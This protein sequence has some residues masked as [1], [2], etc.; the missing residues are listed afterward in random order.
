MSKDIC[1]LSTDWEYRGLKC[2]MLENRY[3]KTTIL[4]EHGARLHEFIYKP[5]DKDFLYHNPRLQPRPPVYGANVDNWWSGGMDVAIPTGHVCTFRGDELP[6]LGEVW[7]QPWHWNVVEQ[8]AQHVEVH[9]WCHTLIAPFLVERW[10]SLD[11]GERF[12]RQRYKVTNVG[13]SAYPFNWG[14]HPGFSITPDYR[15]DLPA[16][17][18]I[19]EESLPNDRLGKR[20]AEYTWP[21]AQDSSGKP[22]DMRQVLPPEAGTC[23]FHYAVE[24]DDGW[25]ALTD[26]AQR[27][28]VGLVFPKDIFSVV[29]MW[30]VYGGWRDI[31][32]A[33]VEAWTGYP[34]K[35]TEAVNGGRH[36][37]LAAG[38]TLE[39]EA[40]L[41]AF[42]GV[43]G[44]AQI[45]A[46]GE[47]RGI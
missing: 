8:N 47:V 1:R 27:V 3:V 13:Y 44:V 42:D 25:L 19:V 32:T 26:T 2:L 43:T 9:S 37:Q 30:L 15:I 20:G 45:N 34:A 35:L 31:Y 5:A 24:L 36:L 46:A 40:L 16:R 10:D 7:S 21:F 29:W 12:L 17:K 28:G 38:E 11:A 33:A 4:I 22:V 41:A 23:E 14:L 6:Y 18:V 39:C